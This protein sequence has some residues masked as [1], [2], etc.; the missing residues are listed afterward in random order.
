MES[1]RR[2]QDGFAARQVQG[3]NQAA[4]EPLLPAQGQAVLIRAV[5][6]AGWQSNAQDIHRDAFLKI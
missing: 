3:G 5:R 6:I 2:I 4:F 1:I